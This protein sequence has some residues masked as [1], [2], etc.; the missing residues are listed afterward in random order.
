MAPRVAE[1]FAGIGL[2]RMAMERAGC[3][4]VYANE[5]D[6]WRKKIYEAN[7]D[8]TGFSCG[9]VRE[10]HGKDVPAIEIATASFPCT[11]LSLAG[12]RAGLTGKD[13]V[14]VSEFLRIIR[15][16][17]ERKPLAVLLENVIGFATSND[18]E[19]L[20]ATVDRLNK[21]G[22]V[23]DVLTL[24]ARRFI[25]QS[26]P[27][28]FVIG[29]LGSTRSVGEWM[30]SELHPAWVMRFAHKYPELQLNFKRLPEPPSKSKKE[31]GDIVEHFQ[32]NNSVWWDA[33]RLDAFLTS[34][35]TINSQRLVDLRHSP[36][37]AYAAAYRRTRGGDAVWEIRG[38]SLAGCLRPSRGGSSKQAV[39]EA[40]NGKVR[41]RWMTAREYARL[42]GAPNLDFGS[43]TEN[44]VKFALGDAVCVPA[45][46]WL[47]R[48]YLVPLVTEQDETR[49]E[50]IATV[51]A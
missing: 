29:I 26:R 38:D 13:S 41:V 40:G 2:V 22:Y 8:A 16:M 1:F 11:D 32:P 10:V 33:R 48:N 34:L 3:R 25:P 30:P 5:I 45:I 51:D 36:N 28:L 15:E 37:I 21:E 7:F 42:Q 17:K 24:D 44:Q 19:D 43:A 23:C 49:L 31:L 4:V 39:V 35:S 18:G 12:N 47:A 46:Q 14:L 50:S 9:D 27:R 20:R 6:A